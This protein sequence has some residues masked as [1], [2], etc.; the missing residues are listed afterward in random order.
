MSSA[1]WRPFCLHLN[2]LKWKEP[3]WASMK[4][5]SSTNAFTEENEIQNAGCKMSVILF[6]LQCVTTLRPRQD[7]RH[8]PDDI[9]KCIFLNENV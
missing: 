2:V 4:F 3:I 1:K 7:G 9:S 8:F 6:R 5:E